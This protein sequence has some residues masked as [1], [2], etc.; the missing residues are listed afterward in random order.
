MPNYDSTSRQPFKEGGRAGYKKGSKKGNDVPHGLKEVKS[1]KWYHPSVGINVATGQ[2]AKPDLGGKLPADIAKRHSDTALFKESPGFS[3]GYTWHEG[4]RKKGK[5]LESVA[6]KG[7]Y[8]HEAPTK[9]RKQDKTWKTRVKDKK[10]IEAAIAKKKEQ[11]KEY[12]TKQEVKPYIK[13]KK[14]T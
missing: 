10:K 6:D 9:D 14:K 11:N 2:R 4:R 12:S 3:G 13:K 8:V 5:R 1:R 7:V